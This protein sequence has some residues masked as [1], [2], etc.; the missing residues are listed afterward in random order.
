MGT[1]PLGFAS[2]YI[3]FSKMNKQI[4]LYS[5]PGQESDDM[6][7]VLVASGLQFTELGL[8]TDYRKHD[9][10]YPGVPVVV[11][12]VDGR[13]HAEYTDIEP[14]GFAVSFGAIVELDPPPTLP[15]ATVSTY[16]P[17]DSVNKNSF[18]VGRAVGVRVQIANPDGTPNNSLNGKMLLCVIRRDGISGQDVEAARLDLEIENAVAKRTIATGFDQGG[19]Y[20]FDARCSE[21]ADVQEHW[22]DVVQ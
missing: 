9:T 19:Q 1:G 2:W 18:P 17:I 8:L 11:V 5:L 10:Q 4:F 16:A 7:A 20:G 14:I 6:R 15:I 12:E 13:I 21:I 22:F 3:G